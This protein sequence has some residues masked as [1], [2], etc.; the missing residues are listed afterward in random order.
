MKCAAPDR[1][2]QVPGARSSEGLARCAPLTVP[3]RLPD[4]DAAEAR[5]FVLRAPLL[6]RGSLTGW[7]SGLSA[8]AA[9]AWPGC[10]RRARGRSSSTARGSAARLSS[11]TREQ[12]SH[13]ELLARKGLFVY[14]QSHQ[15]ES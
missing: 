6:P 8:T 9:S 4:V 12:G 14:R 10:C 15:L 3:S 2:L 1:Y 5:F 13:E 7:S 11:G